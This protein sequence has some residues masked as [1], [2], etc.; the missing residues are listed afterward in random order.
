MEREILKSRA[1]FRLGRRTELD[2]HIFVH[3]GREGGL[4]LLSNSFAF[5]GIGQRI[6]RLAESVDIEPYDTGLDS[7]QVYQGD[8]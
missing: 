5:W 1:P 8:L 3:R 2:N 4:T 6:L 7:P